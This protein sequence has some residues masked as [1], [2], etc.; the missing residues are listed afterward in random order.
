MSSTEWLVDRFRPL[1]DQD[2][3]EIDREL[4]S[5][6]AHSRKQRGSPRDLAV[7]LH[8]VTVHDTRKWFGEANIRLDAFVITGFGNPKDPSTF[9]APKSESFPRIR[10]GEKLPFGPGGWLMFHGPA[11][12]FLDVRIMVSRDRKDSQELSQLL[13]SAAGSAQTGRSLSTLLGL[14]VAAPQAAAVGAAVGAAA[15]LG[16]IAFRLVQAATGATIGL[17]RDCHLEYRDGF[18]I[19]RHP[20]ERAFRVKDLSFWYEISR[21]GPAA[22]KQGEAP[23]A[24]PGVQE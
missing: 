6:G 15:T 21:A 4:A 11:S 19:G 1:T 18:G 8:D 13:S 9:Y 14:A 7:T 17:Y 20:G 10:D 5:G 12:H 3:D 24:T 22:R 2:V 23:S 16:D